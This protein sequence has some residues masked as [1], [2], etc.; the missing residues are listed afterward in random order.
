MYEATCRVVAREVVELS[1]EVIGGVCVF[2]AVGECGVVG[3]VVCPRA[4]DAA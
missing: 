4:E 3:V 1:E 2:E